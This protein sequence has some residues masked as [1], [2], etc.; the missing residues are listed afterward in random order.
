MAVNTYVAKWKLKIGT[1]A[2]E[3]ACVAEAAQIHKGRALQKLDSWYKGENRH[4]DPPRSLMY[5]AGALLSFYLCDDDNNEADPSDEEYGYS[6]IDSPWTKGRGGRA[7]DFFKLGIKLPLWS[8]VTGPL[9]WDE[10]PSLPG[11]APVQQQPAEHIE[12]PPK[13]QSPEVQPAQEGP[14]SKRQ[15]LLG[16]HSL[17]EKSTEATTKSDPA[18][19]QRQEQSGLA[20]QEFNRELQKQGL[21]PHKIRGKR[22]IQDTSSKKLVKLGT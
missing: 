8:T 16:E 12:Q 11:P 5:A 14:A 7:T 19:E 2:W 9:R 18:W 3:R 17:V 10:E 13:Q 15:K 22:Y 6:L 21:E 4:K 1:P 20:P